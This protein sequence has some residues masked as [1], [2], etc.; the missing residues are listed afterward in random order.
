MTNHKGS[1]LSTK[2][3]GAGP[4]Q[5]P[6]AIV[7]MGCL[8]P[9]AADLKE[10]WRTLARGE[11][12]ITEVPPTHWMPADYFD[13][14]PKRPDHTYCTRGGYL[15]PVAFDPTEFGIPP[16]ILEATDT[17]QLLALHVAKMALADAG[18]DDGREFN[19]ERAGVILGITGT[20]ELVISL[21]ARL[22][23]P[24]WRKSLAD[25][26]IDPETAE[27]VIRRISDGYVSWQE[28]SFPGL[29]GNVVAGRIANRLNLRGTNCVIDA[30]CA[31]SL[32]AVHLAMMELATG[33][34]DMILTGGADT[35]NDIFMHMCFSKTP[36]LSPTGDARPFSADSDGTVLGEGI[37]MVVLKR[38]AD[39]E[40]DGDRI[41]A[42]IRGM[43]TSSD[44]RSQSIYAPH[45]AGQARCLRN[46]YE[47]AGIT[48]D[49]ITLIEAHGTGTKVGD[50]TE[51]DG[52]QTVFREARADGK[53][54]ALGSV[55]SQ[56]G[57]TKA[58]AGAAGL[59]KA[60]LALH[61]R[62][63]P[64]TLKIAEPNPKMGIGES[65]FYL[66]TE[67]RPWVANDESPR[68]AGVSSFGFGGSNFHAVLEE[69][70]AEKAEPAWDGSVEIIALSADSHEA[71]RTQLANWRDTAA[72]PEFDRPQIA[73]MAC[74]SRRNFCRDDV[75]RLTIVAER[76][77]DLPALLTKIDERLAASVD[78][79]ALPNAWYANQPA[80]GK[81]AFLFPGQ[82]SQYIGMA[83]RLACTFPEMHEALA[84]ADE[85]S[86]DLQHRISDAIYPLPVFDTTERASNEERLR[87]TEVAQPALGAIEWG[88]ANLLGRFGIRPDAVCG[89]SYGELVALAVAGVINQETLG[90]LTLLRG[91]LM[92]GD[93]TDRGAMLA[94]KAP[95]AE[96]DRMI[97]ETGID[98]VLANRNASDQGVLSGANREI[99]RAAE[100]CKA[101]GFVSKRLQVSGAFHSALMADA[102]EPLAQA[103]RDAEFAAAHVPVIAN[104][105]AKTYPTDPETAKMTLARQLLSPVNFVGQI[106]C[107]YDS[108]IRA[109]IEV[110]PRTVLTGLVGSIL[111]D[112]PH[113]VMA[114]DGSAGRK[115]GIADLAR[116]I[117]RLAAEGREVD[118]T[119]WETPAKEPR[120]PK[121]VVPLVGANYR[122]PRE[123]IPP[124][125]KPV[126]ERAPAMPLPAARPSIEPTVKSPKMSDAPNVPT[127]PTNQRPA[128]PSHPATVQQASPVLTDALRVMQE[129]L[130]SMQA[131]Q[132]QTAAAHER[133]LATQEQAHRAFQQLLETQHRLVAGSLGHAQ[134]APIAQSV[135]PPAPPE[136]LP[137]P[138]P[139]EYRHPASAAFP[140]QQS[141]RVE[142]KPRP[143]IIPQPEA[144][145]AEALPPVSPPPAATAKPTHAPAPTAQQP[146][147]TPRTKIEPVVLQI[148]CEKTGYPLE[149]ITLDMDIEVDLGIDSIKRVEIIAAIEERMPGLPTIKPEHMGSLRT[150]GQIVDFMVGS[151][152]AP[153]T[154]PQPAPP[155]AT[156]VAKSPQQV[157]AGPALSAD[158]FGQTLLSV[159][160]QLTGYPPDMLNL[161]MDMEADLG[162]D[163]IKRV[164]I[165]AGVEAKTPELPPVKPEYMGSLRTL[166]QVVDYYLA[167]SPTAEPSQT[168]PPTT[169]PTTPTAPTVETNTVSTPA[170]NRGV[171]TVVETQPPR[172]RPLNI[173]TDHEIWITDDG[174]GLSAA[175]VDECISAGIT[176]RLVPLAEVPA[177]ARRGVAGLLIV[178]PAATSDSVTG[179][180]SSDAF[181][182]DAIVA[183]KTV[184]ADLATAAKAG[185]AI[186]ATITRLDGAIGL[187]GGD[188]DPVLGGL[189]GL[190]K[191][192]AVEWPEVTCRAIDIAPCWNDFPSVAS[193]V[194]RELSSDGPV[195]VGL[196]ANR[197]FESEV[198]PQT[199]KRG[200]ALLSKGDVVI[201]TGGA[202]GV[203]AE[204]ALALAEQCNPT[205]IL[206]GRSPAPVDEPAWLAPLTTESDIKQAILK[207]AFAGQRPTPAE[208]QAEFDARMAA[209]E[210]MK[211]IDRIAA[212]GAK[213]VYLPVNVRDTDTLRGAIEQVIAR[214]GPIR[215]LIHA[216]GVLEDRLIKHKTAEQFAKVFDTKVV[217]LRNVLAEP[218]LDALRL[219]VFFSSV[220]ARYG[221][222]GQSDYAMA[223]ESLNKIAQRMRRDL[224]KCR[225][226]SIN[227]GPWDGG[228]VTPAL[229]REFVGQGVDLI[230]LAAGA[231]AMVTETLVESGNTEVV[232]GAPLNR[233]QTTR[234][235]PASAKQQST[236]DLS[237]AFQVD[238]DAARFPFIRS[239]VLG[240]RPVLPAAMMIEWMAHAALHANPG[241]VVRSV[242]SLRILKAVSLESDKAIPVTLAVSRPH[243]DGDGFVIDAELRTAR[244]GG[245]SVVHAHAKII[246]AAQ[247]TASPAA[248]EE[249]A[250]IDRA[251]P[252]S[253][254]SAYEENLFHGPHLHGIREIRG[255][256][257]RG[258]VGRLVSAGAPRDWMAEPLRGSWIADP[259]ILDSAFQMAIL[260]CCEELGAPSLP[261]FV[262]SLRL[263]RASMPR[264]GVTCIMQVRD[265]TRSKL[266]AD[267]AFVDAAGALVAEVSD[268]EC[269]VDPLLWD[270]FRPP[271]RLSAAT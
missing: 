109:F 133:F 75:H 201:V 129:G 268:Y 271:S 184:A 49:T 267:I 77:D 158:E 2:G 71:L 230:P 47:L 57:H 60:A 162:I 211:N 245:A 244:D 169:R 106:N 130:R 198:Q 167:Q 43:G 110:G 74:E 65:P 76:G 215:G 24:I 72:K 207:H 253:V 176:A 10:F 23:H 142:E 6:I 260:W 185:R 70:G 239:H 88:M 144:I 12:G 205:L 125:V 63:L 137:L 28:N 135:D 103:I 67:I 208:L 19:R 53:W 234:P 73:W 140:Q 80:D 92:A 240:G 222:V 219:V 181:L 136:Q 127:P 241:L 39:A 263:Y 200:T 248:P 151:E 231:E 62:S 78:G 100:A 199:A 38:L 247:R 265:T 48:P 257:S 246:L 99:E 13:A 30:A 84:A 220:S 117:A 20:Q 170:L 204:A 249:H 237:I 45:A 218:D 14:D 119:K 235:D 118:L 134:P 102:A 232:I 68:R 7:G 188:F 116:V 138:A 89:H 187:A 3:Q 165:L 107:L 81:L 146:T 266:S 132:Q 26:G 179:R 59:V 152:S 40:R 18:Y 251:Y 52:L 182:R 22:G 216:A 34:A 210:I 209:R 195:E 191:T 180:E 194:I 168:A 121:M 206:V 226:T 224:P 101:R 259:L 25:A 225:V 197:R 105:T 83:R 264:D 157:A 86:S 93:G 15:S 145:L 153:A 115:C 58:A 155:P 148:V 82:G 108:G 8:F 54:C 36:A 228:M 42:V 66:N 163:S 111:R 189:A 154:T 95:L 29:L 221:N 192:A 156:V 213:V 236:G 126:V 164:E 178:A 174:E 120:K 214:H 21:G 91:R 4:G 123:A 193:A 96:I 160:A 258:I 33:R 171:L 256:S 217:G 87:R 11:D 190:T 51:F 124:T 255:L 223:N 149:M 202:R 90:R 233:R 37:G 203:T 177:Q 85:S 79:W 104:S 31:S 55:K 261:A 243:R 9:G 139:V 27:D 94:V 186:F 196:D 50:A 175:L 5:S 252:R 172:D 229:R 64:P 270:A 161:D 44:G 17:T 250:I 131:L 113:T 143:V 56:I 69:F 35:L 128:A 61:H 122:S 254:Q 114:V 16:N 41:Y 112:R 238:L 269:T 32:G 166:R 1:S 227:W 173:A 46:A 262:R 97:A 141:A 242:D 212:T 147:S 150:L 183:A 159:V 98:V